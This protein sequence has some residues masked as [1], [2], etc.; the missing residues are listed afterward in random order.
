MEPFSAAAGEM[1]ARPA[2]NPG[3]RRPLEDRN[4]EPAGHRALF[5]VGRATAQTL[6]KAIGEIQSVGA[7]HFVE[8]SSL[9]AFL[10]EMIEAPSVEEALRQ[11]VLEAEAPPAP[12]T[13]RVT[14][15][16]DLRNVMLR[17]LPENIRLSPGRLEITAA[18]AV[19]MLESLAILAQVM[20]NDLE[21]VRFVLESPESPPQI[22]DAELRLLLEG[23]RGRK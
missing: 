12:K 14:L 22:R 7:A 6:M 23:L 20:Q 5:D 21:Q 10:D 3:T 4:L 1:V 18:S 19:L 17:D 13:L 11:R 16:H 2:S 9:L 8:R 15:P